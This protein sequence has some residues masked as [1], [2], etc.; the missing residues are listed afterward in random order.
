VPEQALKDSIARKFNAIPFCSDHKPLIFVGNQANVQ[1]LRKNAAEYLDAIGVAAESVIGPANL[2]RMEHTVES[3]AP[4]L[5]DYPAWPA[6]KSRLVSIGLN[7][8]NPS[9]ALQRVL[10]AR[11]L[12][13]ATDAAAVLG[14]RL[15][16]EES[17]SPG[18]LPGLP[19]VPAQLA[20]HPK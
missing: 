14:W 15:Q 13:S 4:G 3:M 16:Y 10:Q 18:P 1:R 20:Q 2:T 12:D 19:P 17:R 7:G 9:A 5:T 6:L 8:A 11:P